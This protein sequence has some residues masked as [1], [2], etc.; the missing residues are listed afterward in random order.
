MERLQKWIGGGDVKSQEPRKT[1]TSVTI[2]SQ[3]KSTGFTDATPKQH[4]GNTLQESATAQRVN[5]LQTDFPKDAS[6]TETRVGQLLNEGREMILRVVPLEEGDCLSCKLIGSAAMWGAAAFVLFSYP[7]VKTRYTGFKRKLCALQVGSLATTLTLL[8]A[9]RFFDLSIFA[10]Q[11]PSGTRKSVGQLMEEDLNSVHK[12]M[13]RLFSAE[14][15]PDSKRD[16]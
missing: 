15:P 14:R 9:A 5:S 4:E 12:H 7:K 2:A 13:S 16:S 10:V 3:E 8:G 11:D 6:V 1:G